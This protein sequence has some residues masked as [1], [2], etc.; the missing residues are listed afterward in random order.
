MR[1]S[2][3]EPYL[4][5]GSLARLVEVVGTREDAIVS[6]LDSELRLLWASPLGSENLFGRVPSEFEGRDSVEFVHPSDR[7]LYLEGYNRAARGE[8]ASW[9]VRALSADGQYRDVRT[10]AW[11]VEGGGEVA[12]VAITLPVSSVVERGR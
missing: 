1:L 12:F 3:L 11:L 2:D 6:L 8:T 9:Q 5:R 10:V 4:T 7:L